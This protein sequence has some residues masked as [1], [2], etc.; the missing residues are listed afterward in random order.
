MSSEDPNKPYDPLSDKF[1][2]ESNIQ[3]AASTDILA[4]ILEDPN[5]EIRRFREHVD[6]DFS[7]ARENIISTIEKASNAL[8]KAIDVASVMQHPR[9]YEVVFNGIKTLTDANHALLDLSKKSKELKALEMQV[10]DDT[11][12]NVTNNVFVGSMDELQKMLKGAGI[13]TSVR[14]ITPKKDDTK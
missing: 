9:A 5:E 12:S 6:A 10:P 13:E 3:P 2:V 8:N 11:P 4:S 1:G 14:D 7:Y